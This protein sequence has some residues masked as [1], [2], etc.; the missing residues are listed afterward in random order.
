MSSAIQPPIIVAEGRDICLYRSADEAA[1]AV[2]GPDV[3]DGIYRVYDRNARPLRFRTDGGPH[4]YSARV[5][6]VSTGEPAEVAEVESL[7]REYLA[8]LGQPTAAELGLAA[9]IETAVARAGYCR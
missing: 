9:L 7:L 3:L 1:R 4:D 5:T 2:E 8:A 6:V